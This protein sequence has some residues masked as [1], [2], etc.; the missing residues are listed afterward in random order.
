[1]IP[2]ILMDKNGNCA[3]YEA[4]VD[5]TKESS[6]IAMIPM[7][8]K[9]GA[10]GIKLMG[11][12]IIKFN[13][14]NGIHSWPTNEASLPLA[15]NLVDMDDHLLKG[16]LRTAK[17]RRN[18]LLVFGC[19]TKDRSFMLP[20]NANPELLLS[21]EVRE[22][23]EKHD[24]NPEFNIQRIIDTWNAIQEI[25]GNTIPIRAIDNEEDYERVR[26]IC[27]SLCTKIDENDTENPLYQVFNLLTDLMGMYEDRSGM[28][29]A[30]EAD[31][32]KGGND[33]AG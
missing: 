5:P 17:A 3:R 9:I 28:R 4:F 2:V 19:A 13:D 29:A 6:D 15:E 33:A 18:Q 1:M 11:G 26:E 30:M 10:Y 25:A 14:Y 22:A 24:A 8:I 7:K 16:Y 20:M 12:K 21:S 31:M 23:V 27:D 32:D